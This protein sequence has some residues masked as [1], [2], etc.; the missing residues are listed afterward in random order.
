MISYDIGAVKLA[1]KVRN[2][3]R[4][5]VVSLHLLQVCEEFGSASRIGFQIIKA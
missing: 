1:I 2:Y 4:S 3:E 5:V